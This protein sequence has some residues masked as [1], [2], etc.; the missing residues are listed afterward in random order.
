MDKPKGYFAELSRLR[1]ELAWAEVSGDTDRVRDLNDQIDDM[2]N[3]YALQLRR[4]ARHS[5]L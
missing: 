2:L 4:H 5:I 3:I 1:E